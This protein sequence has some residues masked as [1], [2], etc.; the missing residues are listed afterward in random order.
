MSADESEQSEDSVGTPDPEDVPVFEGQWY[1]KATTRRAPTEATTG[2]MSEDTG[3]SDGDESPTSGDGEVSPEDTP[4]F[5]GQT[6][7]RNS[8]TAES[9]DSGED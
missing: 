7:T 4:T 3:N 1:L 2:T 8:D 6:V 5:E 9:D